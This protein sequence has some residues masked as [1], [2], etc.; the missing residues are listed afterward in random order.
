MSPNEQILK[1]FL[2]SVGFQV[3]DNAFRRFMGG[4]TR[5]DS[6]MALVGKTALSVAV[7]AEAMV[8]I[9][10]MSMEKLYYASQRTKA[11][12][13]N[14]QALEY[15]AQQ[16]GIQ[17]DEAR[18][19]LERMAAAVRMNPGL[20]GLLDGL[21]GRSTAGDDQA[22]VMLE[23]VK[24]LGSMPHMAGSQF[25]QMFG[26][27]EQTFLMLKEKMPELEE[28]MKRR[29][30]LTKRAGFEA[31]QAAAAGRA[32]MNSWRDIL[33][34]VEVLT[35]K[36]SVELLPLF[37][38]MTTV[39][40]GLLD[41]ASKWKFDVNGANQFAGHLRS[42][43]DNYMK[44]V[45]MNK[46]SNPLQ[47]LT[48]KIK[49]NTLALLEFVDAMLLVAQGKWSEAGTKLRSSAQRFFIGGPEGL[50]N[51]PPRGP[52]QERKGNISGGTS[53]SGGAGSGR[54]DRDQAYAWQQE[55]TSNEARLN[56]G[57]R[58]EREARDLMARQEYLRSVLGGGGYAPTAMAGTGAG[59]GAGSNSPV[60]LSMKTDIHVNGSGDP[61]TT[62]RSVAG[63]QRQVGSEICRNLEGCVR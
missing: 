17:A 55:L 56:A 60:T 34:R 25:A 6:K 43:V 7:A 51:P 12:V 14:I 11:S 31:D 48:D 28:A 63:A 61:S 3:D 5:V 49:D 40:N 15:G 37:Q 54:Y 23:L 46:N 47:G 35:Q 2:V 42:I 19:S 1:S 58:S 62:A 29:I 38:R 30:E 9:F 52:D 59:A 33:E 24:K 44:L 10:S 32:Y 20:R 26:M 45:E 18:G 8:H 13:G 36:A 21:L 50:F 22:Q 27:D 4:L 16:I 57:L 53:S 41:A 39:I